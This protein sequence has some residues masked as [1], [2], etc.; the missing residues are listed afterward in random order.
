MP[1]LTPQRY[2]PLT[3]ARCPDRYSIPLRLHSEFGFSCL[4]HGVVCGDSAFKQSWES[5]PSFV[6]AFQKEIFKVGWQGEETY[7]SVW[8]FDRTDE[9]LG[10]CPHLTFLIR[11]L[12]LKPQLRSAKDFAF[13]I[14]IL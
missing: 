3:S 13:T 7:R 5:E 12:V 2:I 6:I 4:E 9:I 14:L 1:L 11:K 10:D 8:M